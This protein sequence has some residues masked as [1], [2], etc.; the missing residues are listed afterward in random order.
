MLEYKR[1]PVKTAVT[2]DELNA[3]N[4][5]GDEIEVSMT[6]KKNEVE[7]KQAELTALRVRHRTVS[8]RIV[9]ILEARKQAGLPFPDGWSTA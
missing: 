8:A 7:Q 4:A 3:L 9:R 6:A 1:P 2:D 5:L